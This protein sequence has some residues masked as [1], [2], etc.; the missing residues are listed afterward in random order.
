MCFVMKTLNTHVRLCHYFLS[1]Y[2]S[3]VSR[4]TYIVQFQKKREITTLELWCKKAIEID[5]SNIALKVVEVP[6][7]LLK[8]ENW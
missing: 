3:S 2:Y 1:Y 5:I 7:V 4:I 8:F 6:S